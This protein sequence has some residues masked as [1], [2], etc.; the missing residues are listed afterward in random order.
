[1]KAEALFEV[2]RRDGRAY[3]ARR[4]D[5]QLLAAL[6]RLEAVILKAFEGGISA[7]EA[8]RLFGPSL[9]GDADS[10]ISRVESRF[11]ALL[12]PGRGIAVADDLEG[13]LE[14]DP[15]AARALGLREHT[16]PRVLHWC[17]TRYCP[18]RCVYC[19]A[20]P[21][22]GGRASDAVITR[23]EL[24]GIFAEAVTLGAEHLLVAGSEPFLRR[25]VPEIMGDALANGLTPFVTTKHPI[26]SDLASRLALAGVRHISLSVDS[27]S[28]GASMLLIGSD[29]YPGQ[30]RRSVQ[31]L[32]RAGVEFSVQ[33]V[34]TAFNREDM[35]EVAR[36]AAES[37]ARVMQVVPFEPVRRP[38][39]DYGNDEMAAQDI[40]SLGA[41][42]EQLSEQHPGLQCELF[43]KLGS[44]E[45]AAY[46][47]DIGMTKMFFLPD[48]VVHRC[49]KLID[50][51]GLTGKDLRRCSVAAAWHDPDF[52][53]KISP[54]KKAYAASACGGCARFDGCHEEGRCIYQAL[55][56]HEDYL[57]P[58][59]SCEGPFAPAPQPQSLVS[60]RR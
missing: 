30:V 47:C 7:G 57:A 20:E 2:V 56:T 44:G 52:G 1:M 32:K 24:N 58:D 3:V 60:I 16:G 28:P 37:G 46:N 48:G 9:G 19:Y 33:A 38:I 51:S 50:D 23:E 17:V 27:M 14:H 29:K 34:V 15:S 12:K 21:L 18:R 42:V 43:E 55:F 53:L 5:G 26:T 54:P 13:L 40:E 8:A 31:N 6:T 36:F 59:R 10:V 4:A 41:L 35:R 49:Y 11:D 22:L 45:R 39:T 25:D